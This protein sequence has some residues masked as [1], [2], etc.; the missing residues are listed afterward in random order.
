MK[1]LKV[2]QVIPNTGWAIDK[3]M[4]LVNPSEFEIHRQ[5]M[6]RN[7]TIVVPDY[8]IL[9]FGLWCNVPNE[10]MGKP[11]ILTMHHIE[12]GHEQKV[13]DAIETFKPTI[14]V[15]S[16]KAVQKDLK[17][18]GFKSVLI[19]LA[20][21]AQKLRVGYIGADIPVKRFDI[22]DE[23]CKIAD[24]ECCGLR[25]KNPVPEIPEEQMKNW[26]RLID[27]LVVAALEEPSSMP[28]L[29]AQAVG[30]KVI[31]TKIGMKPH[32]AIWFD[33]SVEDLVKKI[34]KLKPKPLITPE[35]YSRRYSETYKKAYEKFQK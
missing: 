34:N 3:L 26:Y 19:P 25:R 33:G 1:H 32:K 2:L 15:A 31:S 35:E 12:R 6:D 27:V 4:T 5:Y 9:D 29:E 21:P 24:V 22:I 30:T 11:L 18:I 14:I 16:S 28:G 13:K 20:V 10:L 23:A 17:K 7:T 8:D